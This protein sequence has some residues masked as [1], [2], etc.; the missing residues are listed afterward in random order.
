M[1]DSEKLIP[2]LGSVMSLCALVAGSLFALAGCGGGSPSSEHRETTREAAAPPSES[3]T[4]GEE[5]DRGGLESI[6]AADRHAFVQIAIATGDLNTGASVL[7]VHGIARPQD[8][9]TLRRLVPQVAKLAPRDAGLGALRRELLGALRQAIS[10][11]AHRPGAQDARAM[12]ADAAKL[13]AG[14]K[15]YSGAH[16]AIGAVAPD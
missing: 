9:R 4:G 3:Q 10:A 13:R 5:Q 8:L 11:R 15:R 12:L 1:S 7:L 14:L 16:P 6:A 2:R